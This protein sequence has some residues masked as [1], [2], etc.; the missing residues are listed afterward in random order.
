MYQQFAENGA[1]HVFLSIRSAWYAVRAVLIQ[2]GSTMDIYS[3]TGADHT[4]FPPVFPHRKKRDA[5]DP[6]P[7]NIC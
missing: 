1:L 6:Q 3:T 5:I 2:F 7:K 4:D